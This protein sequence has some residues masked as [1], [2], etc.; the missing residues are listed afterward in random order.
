MQK[1]YECTDHM[2]CNSA[3]QIKWCPLKALCMEGFLVET[4]EGAHSNA[5]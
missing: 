5:H 3:T 4:A 1:S 2:W